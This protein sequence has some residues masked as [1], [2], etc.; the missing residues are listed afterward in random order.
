MLRPTHVPRGETFAISWLDKH[1]SECCEAPRPYVCQTL[2]GERSYV[3]LS[4]SCPPKTV[5]TVLKGP[6]PSRRPTYMGRPLVYR[7]RPARSAASA[8]AYSSISRHSPSLTG[9]TKYIAPPPRATFSISWSLAQLMTT[10]LHRGQYRLSHCNALATAAC[11]RNPVNIT[12][13][14]LRRGGFSAKSSTL[15]YV[16]R[17]PTPIP[18]TKAPTCSASVSLRQTNTTRGWDRT[19]AFRLTPFLPLRSI[20]PS[21]NSYIE[22]RLCRAGTFLD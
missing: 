10:L 11:E 20:A 21:P 7:F 14:A 9:R 4:K 8:T 3:N 2:A 5:T 6:N 1:R 17:L 22:Q 13:V 16:T 19:G 18:P 12:S 15:R